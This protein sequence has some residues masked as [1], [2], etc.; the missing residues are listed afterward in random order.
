MKQPAYSYDELDEIFR[1]NGRSGNIGI[2]AIDG[3]IAA[4]VAGPAFVS[5]DEWL[6][7][8]FASRMPAVIEGTPEHLAVNTIFNR[9]NEVSITLADNPQAYRP[10]FMNHEGGVIVNDWAAGFMLA[11][12]KSTDAWT[13]ILL[14][15][16]RKVLAPIFVSHD[17]GTRI[18][19]DL[20]KAEM[21][22]LRAVAHH[23]IADAVISLHE[24]CAPQRA[25]AA[26]NHVRSRKSRR[27]KRADRS[28]RSYV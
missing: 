24:A 18:L 16:M 8:I 14:T 12:G 22:K 21:D 15:D 17:L 1:G 9:Y 26:Q 10:M 20:S 2:S 25:A 3:M 13:K 4:L 27:A 28:R 5:P 7:I 23:H 19:P 11:V 6:P